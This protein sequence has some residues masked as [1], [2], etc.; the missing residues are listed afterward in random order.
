MPG[1]MLLKPCNGVAGNQTASSRFPK[2]A[3]QKIFQNFYAKVYGG[4]RA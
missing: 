1:D 4:V 3:L 2:A